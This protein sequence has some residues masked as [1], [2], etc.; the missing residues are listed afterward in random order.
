MDLFTHDMT[1]ANVLPVSNSIPVQEVFQAAPFFCFSCLAVPDRHTGRGPW[2]T[3]RQ[4]EETCHSSA[5]QRVRGLFPSNLSPPLPPPPPSC[6]LPESSPSYLLNGLVTAS[7]ASCSRTCKS[8]K[9]KKQNKNSKTPQTDPRS[10]PKG[11][12]MPPHSSWVSCIKWK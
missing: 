10:S 3:V 11:L 4:A 8:L 5:Y 6:S 2:L 7:P 9:K 1:P 12:G